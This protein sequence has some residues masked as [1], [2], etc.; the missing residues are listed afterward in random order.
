MKLQLLFKGGNGAFHHRWSR[1]IPKHMTHLIYRDDKH[2]IIELTCI[3]D[4]FSLGAL[5]AAYI[6][7]KPTETISRPIKYIELPWH[8]NN[9]T[10]FKN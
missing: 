4:V 8:K 5:E 9:E 7:D 10:T 6:I 3:S 1:I 2:N